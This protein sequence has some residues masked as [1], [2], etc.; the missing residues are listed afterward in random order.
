MDPRLR[1]GADTGPWC[2]N[3]TSRKCPKIPN[4]IT[5]VTFYFLFARKH[6]LLGGGGWA[7]EK[8]GPRCGGAA[9]RPLVPGT[10]A[11]CTGNSAIFV[12]VIQRVITPWRSRYRCTR[13]TY[14]HDE[15]NSNPFLWQYRFRFRYDVTAALPS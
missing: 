7:A 9:R 11:A 15:R 6:Y 8:T 4:F 2:K 10:V 1:S 5:W 12:R 14:L 13:C 3:L